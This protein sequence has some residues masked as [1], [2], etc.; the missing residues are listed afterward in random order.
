MKQIVNLIVYKEQKN[1]QE[2]QELKEIDR[3]SPGSCRRLKQERCESFLTESSARTGLPPPC[4]S[5][6][7]LLWLADRIFNVFSQVF[8]YWRKPIMAS[9]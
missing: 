1:F 9:C 2:L 8:I 6:E 3:G 7:S 4:E 5:F